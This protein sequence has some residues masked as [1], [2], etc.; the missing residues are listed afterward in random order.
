MRHEILPENKGCFIDSCGFVTFL[1]ERHIKALPLPS[2]SCV[3]QMSL[4]DDAESVLRLNEKNFN[5]QQAE[6]LAFVWDCPRR[7]CPTD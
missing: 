5:K 6:M 2:L 4:F 3:L 1:P 7:C